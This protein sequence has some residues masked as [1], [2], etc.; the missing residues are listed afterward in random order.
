MVIAL[1]K[2]KRPAGFLTEKRCRKLFEQKRAVRYRMFPMVVILKDIDVRTFTQPLPEYRLKIDPGAKYDGF[3]IIDPVRD[4]VVF[5]LQVEHRAGQVKQNL[6][7]R[8]QARRNR[9]SRETVYRKNKFAQGGTFTQTGNEGKFPPSIQ[10]ILANTETWVKRLSRWVNLTS[11]SLEAV[12]FDTQL[13]D[14]PAIEG[15]EYQQGTLLGTEIRE[16]L[17][18]RYQHT[19]QYCGGVSGDPVLEWEHI[20]PRSRGGSDSIKN[21]TLACHRCNQ[22][23]G[24]MTPEEWAGQLKTQ[25]TKLS[26]ARLQGIEKVLAGK[27]NGGSSRYCAWVNITRKELER[28]LFARFGE[29]ECASGG[30]TKHNRTR[31]GFPKDH[32]YDA[33]CV[34]K[35]PEQGYTDLTHGYYALA[36]AVGHGS[37]FRG[38]INS[39]GI[40]IQKLPPREKNVFGFMNGDI[41]AAD[42]PKRENSHTNMKAITLAGS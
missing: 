8:R 32:Q 31:L 3:A 26:R 27:R 7:A 37:H 29:V 6:D 18:D 13:L 11:V 28:S 20:R 12:R 23:K 4:T 30:R 38:K 24:S 39:C 25:K 2:N 10:S 9:R 34:G 42:I 41:V 14:D 16:Y 5:T 36:K 21:A 17:L 1:D 15:K 35:V 19:C 40:I 33:A 22:D